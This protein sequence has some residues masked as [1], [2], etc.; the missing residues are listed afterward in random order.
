MSKKSPLPQ[1]RRHLLIFDEDW[2][3][4]ESV[5][6]KDSGPGSIGTGVAVR[7]FIHSWVG[8]LKARA[9]ARL[10]ATGAEGAPSEETL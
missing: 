3:F 4:L 2:E 7:K 5:Y 10:D 6:G 1:S 9:L 8:M